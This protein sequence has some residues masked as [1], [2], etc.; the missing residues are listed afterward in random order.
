[1]DKE[2]IEFIATNKVAAV[3]GAENN[4]PHCFNCFYAYMEEEN[5]IVFKSSESTKHMNILSKNNVVAG[6][7]HSP[8]ISIAKVQ[9]IQ[10]DGIIVS[11]NNNLFEAAKTYYA[12]YPFALAVP[13]TLWI[14]RLNT[15]KY[16]N[17]VNGIN[18]KLKWERAAVFA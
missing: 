8:D 5:C 15:I 14:I 18:N 11:K 2:I 3:C 16:T 1:M 10:F 12:R 9:G 6:T 4:K 7:I 17:T 13:G